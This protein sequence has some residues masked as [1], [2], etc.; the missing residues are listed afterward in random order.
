MNRVLEQLEGGDLRSDGKADDVAMQVIERPVLLPDLIEGFR[1]ENRLIRMRTAHALEVI[2][3]NNA[4]LL[5]NYKDELIKQAKADILPETRWHLAQ[6]FGSL[7]F[8]DQELRIVLPLLFEF[9]K[10]GTTLVKAWTVVGLGN[11]AASN[12][13]FRSEI[14][15][16]ISEYKEDRSPAVRNRVKQALKLLT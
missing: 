5:E 11:I 16:R 13:G 3:R 6:I 4:K 1:S 8:S 14:L 7:S 15:K 12:P 9:L 10:N 2:S